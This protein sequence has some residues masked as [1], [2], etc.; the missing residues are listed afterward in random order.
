M[1]QAESKQQEQAGE[2]RA[3]IW[4]DSGTGRRDSTTPGTRATKRETGDA[5]GGWDGDPWGPSRAAPAAARQQSLGQGWAGAPR[6]EPRTSPAAVAVP[7]EA[8][9]VLSTEAAPAA[10]GRRA[11]AAG[12]AA[13]RGTGTGLLPPAPS[14]DPSSAHGHSPSPQP[15]RRPTARSAAFLHSGKYSA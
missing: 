2:L 7:L 4:A 9:L 8:A 3:R 13:G 15:T 14:N 12:L 5:G 1:C 6:P 11:A 10:R